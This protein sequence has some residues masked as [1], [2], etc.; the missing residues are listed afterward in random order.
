M[1]SN[2]KDR[3]VATNNQTAPS[4]NFCGNTKSNILPFPFNNKMANVPTPPAQAKNFSLSGDRIILDDYVSNLGS[5]E[6]VYVRVKG[7]TLDLTSGDLVVMD[8]GNKGK[9]GDYIVVNKNGNH[10]ITIKE[11]AL[12]LVGKSYSNQGE[13]VGTLTHVIR[14]LNG[15]AQ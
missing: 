13:I 8:C 7:E 12:T 11:K 14:S 3:A 15:G 1:N 5:G 9:T 6:I 10:S 2:K 4:A